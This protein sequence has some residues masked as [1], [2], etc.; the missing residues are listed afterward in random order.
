MPVERKRYRRKSDQSIWWY[1]C[2]YPQSSTPIALS[3]GVTEIYV[4]RSEFWL[5]YEEAQ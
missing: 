3:N 4:T 2:K 5:L 1:V